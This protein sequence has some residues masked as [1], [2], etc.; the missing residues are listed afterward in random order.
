MPREIRTVNLELRADPPEQEGGLLRF[1]G[2][3]AVFNTLTDIYDF[4]EQIAPGAFTGSLQSDDIRCLFNHDANHVLG[5]NRSGT[6]RL[7]ED[8]RG[9]FFEVDAPGAQWARDLH[10]SVQRGDVNQCSFAFECIRDQ[11]RTVNGVEERTLL[12]V[13]LLDVSI[14][15]YPAY[16][17]TLAVARSAQEVLDTHLGVKRAEAE[18][19]KA[20]ADYNR[21]RLSLKE[22]ISIHIPITGTTRQ[23]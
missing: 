11:W 18:R 16:P 4:R 3:A 10:I 6:L 23:I 5:R 9:L 22:K 13:K 14:V 2:Y 21:A 1:G 17:S 12:E 8:E 15:T 7:S 19:I 20:K